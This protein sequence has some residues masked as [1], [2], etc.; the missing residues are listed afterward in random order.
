[1]TKLGVA[2]ATEKISMIV[3]SANRIIDEKTGEVRPDMRQSARE[4]LDDLKK[5]MSNERLDAEL[6]I[7]EIAM[8]IRVC[9]DLIPV[10]Q[11]QRMQKLS[12]ELQDAI[13][14][15]SISGMEYASERAV[16]ELKN[17]PDRVQ[18]ISLCMMGIRRANQVNPSES[19]VMADKLDRLLGAMKNNQDMEVSRIAQDLFPMVDRY[20]D[21]AMPSTAI[22]TGL[23]R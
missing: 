14:Q 9:G 6:Y 2:A 3:K 7:G 8:M 16:Q 10:A 11:T 20:V 19:R 13:N 22:S 5:T 17:L 15:N 12:Q 18:L 21:G 23:S 4:E 1:L